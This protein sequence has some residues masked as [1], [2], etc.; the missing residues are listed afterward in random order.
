MN[1]NVRLIGAVLMGVG[2]W[3][4]ASQVKDARQL[5]HRSKKKLAKE[6]VQAWEGEGGTINEAAPRPIPG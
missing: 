1:S 6:A 2:A 5:H 3:L 4:V